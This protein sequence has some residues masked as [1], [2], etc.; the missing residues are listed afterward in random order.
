IIVVDRIPGHADVR[1]IAMLQA[2]VIVVVCAVLIPILAGVQGCDTP[3][4]TAL[5]P[6]A[7]PLPTSLPLN[8]LGAAAYTGILATALA[9]PV[10]VWAQRILPPSDAGMIFAM[11]SPFAV[12]FGILVLSETLTPVG[13][14]GSGLIFAAMLLTTLARTNKRPVE[15]AEPLRAEAG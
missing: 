12:V 8:M 11:E 9:L 14:L 13:A 4:C 15:A 5:A 2:L 3:L 7:E 10:Q 1:F 6:F